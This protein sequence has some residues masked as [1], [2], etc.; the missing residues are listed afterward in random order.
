MTNTEVTPALDAL[1]AA[2]AALDGAMSGNTKTDSGFLDITELVRAFGAAREAAHAAG[3]TDAEILEAATPADEETDAAV[4]DD[5]DGFNFLR[6]VIGDDLVVE[7]VA[8]DADEWKH[9]GEGGVERLTAGDR[10][11]R[12]AARAN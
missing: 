8:Y 6:D 7:G 2:T 5:Y 10:A 9:D 3:H 12:E 4:V 11:R 1:A